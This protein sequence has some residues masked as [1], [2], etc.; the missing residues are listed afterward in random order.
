M[1]GLRR[2][3]IS[4][5]T[6]RCRFAG[7][8]T[9]ELEWLRYNSSCW[10]NTRAEYEERLLR[11]KGRREERPVVVLAQVTPRLLGLNFNE[12]PKLRDRKLPSRARSSLG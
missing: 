6:F 7:H 1:W 9:T 5:S 2:D 12:E 3:R 4:G 11:V 8:R 10:P